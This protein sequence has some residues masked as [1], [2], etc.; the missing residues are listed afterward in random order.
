MAVNFTVGP[1]HAID[2]LRSLAL[3][4]QIFLLWL[5]GGIHSLCKCSAIHGDLHL[6]KSGLSGL[7]SKWLVFSKLP[8]QSAYSSSVALLRYHWSVH[9]TTSECFL[10]TREVRFGDAPS[11]GVEIGQRSSGDPEER[12][13]LPA[14]RIPSSSVPRQ[15]IVSRSLNTVTLFA[16]YDSAQP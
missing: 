1:H 2:Q 3:W 15:N 10:L 7:I 12:R 11:T 9:L 4:V 5:T 6:A 8:N 14:I 16:H 13:R